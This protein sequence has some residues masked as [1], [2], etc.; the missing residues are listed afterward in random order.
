MLPDRPHKIAVTLAFSFLVGLTSYTLLR[1]IFGTGESM[2]EGKE[3][4]HFWG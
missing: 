3:L 2:M 4:K 1:M